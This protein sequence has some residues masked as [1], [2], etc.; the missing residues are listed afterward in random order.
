MG[1]YLR[2][3]DLAV[4]IVY[5]LAV[6]SVGLYFYRSGQSRTTAGFTAAGRSLPGWAVGLSIMATYLSSISFLALPGRSYA[7]D[8]NAFVFSLSLPP[9]TWIAVRWFLPYYRASGEV[10]AYSHLEHRFGPWARLYAGLCYLLTQLARIGSVTFLMALPLSVLLEWDIRLVILLTGI[11]VVVYTMMGGII[12]VIWTD[13]IQSLVLMGGAGVCLLIMVLGLPEGPGQLFALAAA[14]H[15]FSLGSYGA[16]LAEP[17]FW[18]VLVYGFTINLQNFGIDQN[19]VQRYVAARSDVEAR[20]SVWLGGLLYVPVSAVFVFLGTALFAFYTAQPDLLPEAYRAEGMADRVFP[21]FI[22]TQLP[23]GVTGLLIAAIF[24]AAMST[25]STS[26]NSSATLLLTDFYT[27]YLRPAASERESM[28]VLQ[29]GTLVWG[30]LGTGI[31]LAMINVQAALDAWWTLS[32]IFAGGM[33]GLFLLG[34]ISRRA[35]NPAAATG[36]LLGV[37]VIVWMTLSPDCETLPEPLRSPLHSFLTIVVGTL[38]ILLVGLLVSR[39][40]RLLGR[41]AP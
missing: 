18:V 10:S 19:Y 35:G 31:A 9:A 34:M 28:R 25:I 8:W 37:L 41:T 21:Y 5:F 26:L 14:E 29:I 22:V 3:A 27:R 2:W 24:A 1:G 33:V 30:L 40:R 4:L 17:T 12:A 6:L 36:V 32:G 11:S 20:K 13:A 7:E 15:K 38:T 23:P 39:L 16:S